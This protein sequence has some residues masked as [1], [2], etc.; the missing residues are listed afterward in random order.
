[1]ETFAIITVEPNEL[2]ADKTGHDRMPLIV[3]YQALF[4]G[5]EMIALW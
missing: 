5:Q 3:E 4:A 2:V 1:M